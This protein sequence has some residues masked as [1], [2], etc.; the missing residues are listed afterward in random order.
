MKILIHHFSIAMHCGWTFITLL[1]TTNRASNSPGN[2]SLATS[3]SFF[4]LKDPLLN[5]YHQKAR[6]KFVKSEQLSASNENRY[7]CASTV[8]NY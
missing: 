3:R 4:S 5:F 2:A 1:K 7:L 8:V 6:A